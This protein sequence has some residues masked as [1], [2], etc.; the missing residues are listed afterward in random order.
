MNSAR[1]TTGASLLESWEQEVWH[2][3]APERWPLGPGALATDIDFGPGEVVIL[4]G[5]PGAGKTALATAGVFDALR[6]T[7][8]L[9]ALIC[10]VEMAPG[11]LLNR[12]LARLSGIPLETIQGR[13]VRNLGELGRDRITGGMDAL[14]ALLPR[15]AF[16]EHPY[17][18]E[19]AALAADGFGAGCILLDY[20]QR[21][22]PPVEQGSQRE[23]IEAAMG[24]VRKMAQAGAGILV[25]SAVARQKGANGSNYSGLNLASLRGSSELEFAADSAYVLSEGDKA[26]GVT[27]RCLKRRNGETKHIALRF[28]RDLQRFTPEGTAPAARH[29]HIDLSADM[30]AIADELDR[31]DVEF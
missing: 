1:F 27:L 21:I 30:Q 15:V 4:G 3:E 20:V 16:L 24:C 14:R 22:A 6:V 10:N 28:E 9:R 12:Q 31:D 26:D 13:R 8:E 18:L 11:A 19:H 23:N 29:H 7:P 25:L 5:A 17:T 2:G